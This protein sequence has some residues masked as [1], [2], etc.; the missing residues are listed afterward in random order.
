MIIIANATILVHI[1]KVACSITKLWHL[2][3]IWGQLYSVTSL[4][5]SLRILVGTRLITGLSMR[6][7]THRKKWFGVEVSLQFIY[8][9]TMY[10]IP[11]TVLYVD[12]GCEFVTDSCHQV[13]SY[14]YICNT[15]EPKQCS[16]DITTKV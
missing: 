16:I 4:L 11:L 7:W 14:P 3:L 8:N 6:T 12:L 13:N 2:P 1:G 10:C 5:H 9:Y 15:D